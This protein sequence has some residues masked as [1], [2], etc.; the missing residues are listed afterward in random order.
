LS[1]TTAS[2]TDTSAVVNMTIVS[3]GRQAGGKTLT[4]QFQGT[5]NLVRVGGDWKLDTASIKR[6][7]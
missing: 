1:A 2:Q 6:A 7:G 5:W 4:Q 3:V